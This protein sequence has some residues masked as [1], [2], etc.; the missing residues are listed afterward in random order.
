MSNLNPKQIAAAYFLAKGDKA[1]EAA[2]KVGVAPETISAWRRNPTFQEYCAFTRK[3]V[4]NEY[5][6]RLRGLHDLALDALRKQLIDGKSEAVRFRAAQAILQQGKLLGN[7][8]ISL[9]D[10]Y[11]K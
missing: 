5:I 1:C 11:D 2:S 8:Q 10:C 4:L 9:W 3:E 6:D 7:E